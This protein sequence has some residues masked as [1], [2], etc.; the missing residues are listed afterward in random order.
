LLSPLYVPVIECV[1]AERNGTENDALPPLNGG[2]EINALVLSKTASESSLRPYGWHPGSP[3]AT[4]NG[5]Y[6]VA[7]PIPR[8]LSA[9][10]ELDSM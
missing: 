3:K 1:P 9:T 10:E 2:F 4:M 7:N 6:R 8:F 5:R